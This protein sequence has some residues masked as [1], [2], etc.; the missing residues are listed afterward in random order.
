MENKLLNALKWLKSLVVKP[1][2][3]Q[4]ATPTK[5]TVLASNKALKA[6]ILRKRKGRVRPIV[7]ADTEPVSKL[8]GA[9]EFIKEYNKPIKP[10]K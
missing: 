10:I 1:T 5:E 6:H 8:L 3:A 9:E 7:K 2:L 4:V